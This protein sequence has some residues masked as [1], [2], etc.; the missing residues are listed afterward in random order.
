MSQFEHLPYRPCVG[1]MLINQD[2]KVW[3]GERI[4]TP[5]AWQM[6]QGGIDEGETPDQAA[7]RELEE[8]TGLK[9][10][11]VSIL[12]M[13][14]DWLHYDLPD[15]RIPLFWGGR[16]RGQK[17]IWFLIRL[18]SWDNAINIETKHPEF[19]DWQWFDMNDVADHAVPFKRAVYKQVVEQFKGIYNTK[20]PHHP[21]NV[22]LSKMTSS[23]DKEDI[24]W[25]QGQVLYNWWNDARKG[26]EFPQKSQFRPFDFPALLPNIF[27]Y[28]VIWEDD[29]PDI[30]VHLVGT[31][32]CDIIGYNPTGY[33]LKEMPN[34]E[35][36]NYRM[37][38]LLNS[39]EPY[40]SHHQPLIWGNKKYVNYSVL[41]LPLS[42]EQ[43]TITYIL[44]LLHF[45]Q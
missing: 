24:Q 44:S 11:D 36:I 25:D 2:G 40:V 37:A 45:E 23:F 13:T 29:L 14:S 1:I 33:K 17:Q 16:Y 28:K 5:N 19:S 18:H 15:D 22:A 39:R 34:G 21:Q 35:M 6:P 7:L 31:H 26:D 38:K 8:E 9:P 12:D 30:T 42:D 41:V 3:L 27:L 20:S 10:K 4:D 32:I 43:G